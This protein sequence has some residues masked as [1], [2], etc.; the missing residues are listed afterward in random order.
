M[1]HYFD[2]VADPGRAVGGGISISSFYAS[3]RLHLQYMSMQGWIQYAEREG[4]QLLRLIIF[5]SRINLMQ[6]QIQDVKRGWGGEA[7]Y[8]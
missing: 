4:L 6:W 8:Q 5:S 7:G 1:S 2:A 3:Y